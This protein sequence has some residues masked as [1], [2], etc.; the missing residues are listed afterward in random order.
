MVFCMCMPRVICLLIWSRPLSFGKIY[1]SLTKACFV[2]ASTTLMLGVAQYFTQGVFMFRC[3]LLIVG[4]SF[5]IRGVVVIWRSTCPF[6]GAPQ[7]CQKPTT[8]IGGVE[9][10][11]MGIQT[12]SQS[13][14]RNPNRVENL[15]QKSD[16]VEDP[17]MGIQTGSQSY[18]RN[19]NR[20]KNLR[21]ESEGG[22]A[23]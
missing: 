3:W 10:P 19:L 23:P 21:Q 11:T 12:E 22:R 13:Y 17:T 9:N 2:R 20:V 5:Y 16:G 6:K 15:R 18:D 1:C 4:S 7:P 14:D 8:G